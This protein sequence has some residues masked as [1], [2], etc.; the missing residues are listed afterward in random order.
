MHKISCDS[1]LQIF[2]G[3][4]TDISKRG[5]KVSCTFLQIAQCNCWFLLWIGTKGLKMGSTHTL[6][7]WGDFLFQWIWHLFPLEQINGQLNLRCCWLH[8]K[9]QFLLLLKYFGINQLLQNSW[10]CAGL[11]GRCRSH[12]SDTV[13]IYVGNHG[14]I[15]RNK[16]CRKFFNMLKLELLWQER[17]RKIRKVRWEQAFFNFCI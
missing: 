2:P 14:D 7:I 10:W 3:R 17:I 9:Q 16:F 12:T 11:T 6:E 13:G 8:Y 5:H 4:G 15:R 1:Q